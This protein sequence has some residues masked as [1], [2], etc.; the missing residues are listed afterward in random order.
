M[1][2][3]VALRKM[4]VRVSIAHPPSWLTLLEKT[5]EIQP[6]YKEYIEKTSAFIPWFSRKK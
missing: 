4:G 1:D 2:E 3:S 6:G 5:L